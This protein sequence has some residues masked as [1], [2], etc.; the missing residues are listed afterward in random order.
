MPWL[1]ALRATAHSWWHFVV[2]ERVGYRRA[3]VITPADEQRREER[4]RRLNGLEV[5][6]AMLDVRTDITA[7]P[8]KRR[9]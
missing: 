1:R 5:L 4:D 6:L 7:G 3:S 9:S 8:Q 2:V